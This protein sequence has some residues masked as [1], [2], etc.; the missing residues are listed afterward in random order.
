MKNNT[1]I[2]G[3]IKSCAAALLSGAMILAGGVL[4][5]GCKAKGFGKDAQGKVKVLASIYPMYDFVKRIGGDLVSVSMM[6][7]AGTEPHAW[8]PSTRD[9]MQLEEADLFVYSGAGMETW[10]EDVLKGVQNKNLT[11]LEASSGVELIK[12]WE[13]DHDDHDEHEEHEHEGAG[14]Y[15]G[16]YDPHVWLSP[17][18]AAIEMKN[19]AE[20]LKKIDP[21]HASDYDKNYQAAKDECD[22]LDGE[23]AT[24]LAGAEGK[25][26]VVAHEAYGYLCREYGLKQLGIE[27]VSADQE[28]DAARMRE[29]IDLVAQYGVKCIFFEELV[30]PKVAQTIAEEAG[31][32]TQA[33]SPLDGLTQ[34]DIDAGRDYFSV[35][36]DNLAAI[37]KAL[38]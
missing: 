3:K 2:F 37:K 29:I 17:K 11:V 19:I 28:P 36:Q 33:L 18:N 34:A 9:M 7:P 32:S 23:F 8:E 21:A 31:C 4:L 6:V 13:G 10:A 38:G 5:P 26:I 27:G 22:K 20:A 14:H 35:M 15:H 1:S 30:N 24:A 12:L 25:Y 16:E